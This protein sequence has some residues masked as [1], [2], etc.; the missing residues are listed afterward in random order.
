MSDLHTVR[1]VTR[2]KI[3][4]GRVSQV[5]RV[6]GVSEVTTVGVGDRVGSVVL[7]GR[8]GHLSSRLNS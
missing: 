8:H 1:R 7:A 4:G 5:D 2:P 6:S 3:G